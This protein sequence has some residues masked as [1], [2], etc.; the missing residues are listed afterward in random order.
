MTL[1]IMFYNFISITIKYHFQGILF[2]VLFFICNYNYHIVYVEAFEKAL[3]EGEVDVAYARIML[4]GTGGVG[5]T[6]FKRSLMKLPWQPHTTSTIIS[7]VEAIRPFGYEWQTSAPDENEKW[8]KVTR[9]DEMNELAQLLAA[10]HGNVPRFHSLPSN[11]RAVALFSAPD[12]PPTPTIHQQ[13]KVEAVVEQ[14]TV[15]DVL[16]EAIERANDMSTSDIMNLKPQPF[17][18]IWDCGGQPVF[19]E[20]LP[21]FLTSRTMF[22]L[23][24]DASK[25]LREKWYT[26]QHFQGHQMTGEISSMSTLNLLL[27][28]MSIIH[29]HLGQH[30]DMGGICDYP[31][32][33]CLGTHGDKLTPAK[34]VEIKEQLK[35]AYK[36]KAF[37]ELIVDTFI[38]DNT[39]SGSVENEDPS[40][41]LVRKAIREFTFKKLIVQTPVSW[42]LFRKIIQVLKANVVTL[43]EAQAIGKTCKIPPE[44]VPKV[45]MF[46]HE[47]GV[48]L[49][50]PHIKGLQSK[51]IISP[52]WFVE[53]M[54][55]VFTL[56]GR[57]ELKSS[58]MWT[59]LREKGLLIRRYYMAVW[60]NDSD[61]E[62]DAIMELLVHF[63]LAAAVVT[64]QYHFPRAKQFFLPAALPSFS[65]EVNKVES[66]FRYRPAF[67]HITFS[68]K[69]VPPGFFT[70]FVTA[71]AQSHC[72]NLYFDDGIYRNR[73]TFKFGDPAINQVILTDL[74]YAIQIDILR[75][76][77]SS[78][79]ALPFNKAC[80]KLLNV[81][82]DC[83]NKVDEVL[84]MHT[85]YSSTPRLGSLKEDFTISRNF[86]YVCFSDNCRFQELHYLIVVEEQTIDLLLCCE[87]TKSYR[88]PT[89]EECFWFKEEIKAETVRQ[90]YIFN[91]FS[92]F[93]S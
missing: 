21:A 75:Y 46:Y 58:L 4:L 65:G 32:M 1:F 40:I 34:K 47:L 84:S 42:V 45:L 80:H 6:S 71:M 57:E 81:L 48:L 11:M 12:L 68:T 64:D 53:T 41:S 66:G 9:E 88:K 8:R 7:D 77:P 20:I 69:F 33:I 18:H 27:N 56:K 44:E 3:S 90:D 35:S 74:N 24:F 5:K 55:K 30:E 82:E 83:G 54:G 17:L 39:T 49:F 14:K 38:V 25:D 52:K 72:C 87:K 85:C 59:L 89:P 22:L 23:L 50:Y 76:V 73:V 51:V 13:A 29:A 70:R 31:R 36:F 86:R 63:R 79:A 62:P 37:A 19:L 67:L 10:V 28:W 15:N 2:C 43:E 93:N 78:P 92:Y 60:K 91:K 26:T 61:L 16:T